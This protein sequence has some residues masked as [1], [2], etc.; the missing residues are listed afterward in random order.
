MPASRLRVLIVD[1]HEILRAG[2]EC[3]L[4]E[5]GH[6]VVGMANT[7]AKA[8]SAAERL[9][10]DLIL[11]DVQLEDEVDGIDA[12][13][14]IHDRLGIQSIFFSGYADPQTRERALLAHPIAFLDKTSSQ[15]ELAE[16]INAAAAK[17]K[18]KPDK[19]LRPIDYAQGI[20]CLFA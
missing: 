7:R 16:I 8:I 1:D 12:A 18:R 20:L 3:V 5:L 15:A 2:L 17:T 13:I 10:P 4:Q 11:M 19:R 9:K 14:E 6:E